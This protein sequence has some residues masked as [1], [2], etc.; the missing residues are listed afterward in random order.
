MAAN[1]IVG[2]DL[3]LRLIVHRGRIGQEAALCTASCRRSFGRPG[4]T[5]ILPWKYAGRFLVENIFEGLA[6]D[7]ALAPHARPARS[8]RHVRGRQEARRRSERP[9]APP[10]SKRRK[11]WRRRRPMPETSAKL[12]NVRPGA[13][14]RHACFRAACRRGRARHHVGMS[15]ARSIAEQ[16]DQTVIGLA[17]AGRFPTWLLRHG[18][19]RR[20][21]IEAPAP[22][23]RAEREKC[24]AA[25]RRRGAHE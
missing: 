25:S 14:P 6:A 5:W 4:A 10:P 23:I 2:E 9:C 7:A 17:S 11:I 19:I 24:A 21:G 13:D 3:K 12:S 8:Y 20:D 15:E 18:T 1:N 22:T 16:D